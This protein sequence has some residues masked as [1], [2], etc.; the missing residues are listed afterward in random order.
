MSFGDVCL[1]KG[2]FFPLGFLHPQPQLKKAVRKIKSKS[3]K[4]K[5]THS[6]FEE[7]HTVFIMRRIRKSLN[8][9]SPKIWKLVQK[10]RPKRGLLLDS[11][12]HYGKPKVSVYQK[13]GTCITCTKEGPCL[14]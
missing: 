8:S 10:H 9:L 6:F 5:E 12:E 7:A 14:L 3:E 1:L 11:R 4:S 13:L 2:Q